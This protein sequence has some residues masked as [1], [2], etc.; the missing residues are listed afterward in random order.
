MNYYKSS[1]GEI[2]AYEADGSQDDLIGNKTPIS[3]QEAFALLDKRAAKA[4]KNLPY[5]DKRRTEY[6][7]IEDYIDG[8][9]KGDQA[10]IDAYIAACMAVKEKYPKD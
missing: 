6:P 4:F 9:V 5:G 8:V 7:P 3:E 2:F 1:S 10:Q